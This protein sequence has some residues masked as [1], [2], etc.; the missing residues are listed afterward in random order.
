MVKQIPL[1]QGKFALVDD[2]DFEYLNQWKW[3]FLPSR[4][5]S[6]YAIR[7]GGNSH[8]MMHRVILN[9]PSGMETDH[10]NHDKLD[11]R[12]SN[13]RIC[14]KAENNQNRKPYKKNRKGKYKG[15][16]WDEKHG[17]WRVFLTRNK[18]QKY[19]GMFESEEDAYKATIEYSEKVGDSI[20]YKSL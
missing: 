12:R 16:Y 17:K 1:T 18:K 13:L 19:L 2:E 5:G 9:T 3:C 6:G 11:N 8:L 4:S 15:V 14:T 10:I 20:F 7:N